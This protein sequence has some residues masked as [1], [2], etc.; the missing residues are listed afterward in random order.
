MIQIRPLLV[1]WRLLSVCVLLLMTPI[2]KAELVDKIVAI[3]NSE[4]IL[5]SDLNR[6]YATLNLR[7]EIDPLFSLSE[8]LDSAK[9]SKQAAVDYLI[10]ERLI[11]LTFKVSDAEADQEIKSVMRNNN[12][13]QESLNHFLSSR[14]FHYE[15][16]AEIMKIGLQKRNLLDREIRNRVNISD[17][18]V[19]NHYFNQVLKT[20]KVPL[21]YSIQTIAIPIKDYRS[22]KFALEAAQSALL[23]I[24][25][26]ESFTE[27]ARRYSAS[28]AGGTG[29]VGYVPGDQ[30]SPAILE[31]VKKLKLGGTS[32]IMTLGDTYYI[33]HLNDVR[34]LENKK[35]EEEKERIRENLA[36]VEY[37]RQLNIWS[38]RSRSAAYVKTNQF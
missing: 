26:G 25:Q 21:E 36:K 32:E 16:Y 28:S 17:D 1:N 5:L 20:S 19:R 12:L 18:D 30:L 38:D 29:D 35:Y 22:S 14:G 34:S 10:T 15:E 23:A 4:I 27:V 8:G 2:A 31:G 33:V 7:R 24:Q 3:V 37:R 6:F 13:T 11:A 9:P